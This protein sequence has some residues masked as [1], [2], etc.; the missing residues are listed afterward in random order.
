MQDGIQNHECDATTDTGS[1]T[2]ME[3]T[4]NES[5]DLAGGTVSVIIFIFCFIILIYYD[6][7][8]I[9]VVPA[10]AETTF[11]DGILFGP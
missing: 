6:D 5:A 11:V 8:V 9:R 7:N 10:A 4:D 2:K 1:R 3:K